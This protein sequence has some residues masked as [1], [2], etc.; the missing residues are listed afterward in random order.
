MPAVVAGDDDEGIREFT[1]LG[2]EGEELGG[3]GVEALDFVGI[4]V[5]F[6]ADGRGGEVGWAGARGRGP[7]DVGI[8]AA[9]PEAEGLCGGLGVKEFGERGVGGAGG[10]VGGLTGAG[11]PTFA[12]MA[13]VIAGLGEEFG[14]GGLVGGE[15]AVKAGGGT[16]VVGP[17][18]GEEAGAGGGAAWIG[19][20]GM[21]EESAFGG[22]TVEG[23]GG[24]SA[25]VGGGVGIGPV[26]G[27][28]E[29]NVG[30]RGGE[31][32]GEKSTA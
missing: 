20:E 8:V 29:E 21:V 14:V 31:G 19:G 6:E 5:E 13:D 16:E 1:A 3:F 18:A 26:V 11:A 12:G 7:G 17:L 15:G 22:D 23:G 4:G 2:E 27:E 32:G 28:E 9:E 25:V 10:I 30:S 24:Y